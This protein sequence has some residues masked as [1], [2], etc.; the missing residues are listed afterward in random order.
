MVCFGSNSPRLSATLFE[1]SP[2]TMCPSL[3]LVLTP[4]TAN[5]YPTR[6]CFA[7]LPDRFEHIILSCGVQFRGGGLKWLKGMFHRTMPLRLVRITINI[8]KK[9]TFTMFEEI[10]D[11]IEKDIERL[12]GY[13]I[14]GGENLD[15]FR[16]FILEYKNHIEYFQSK[17]ASQIFKINNEKAFTLLPLLDD[18]EKWIKKLEAW[19]LFILSKPSNSSFGERLLLIIQS[20]LRD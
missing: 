18:Y 8:E 19:S 6:Y 12:K 17:I 11:K 7:R 9:Y 10:T 3:C 2:I 13:E 14:H 15:D 20:F 1:P 5:V 16:E 4:P